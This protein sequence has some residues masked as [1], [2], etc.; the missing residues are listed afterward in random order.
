MGFPKSALPGVRSRDWHSLSSISPSGPGSV[1]IISVWSLLFGDCSLRR[2]RRP[3]TTANV[4]V[5]FDSVDSS[6]E[7]RPRCF[8]SSIS[9]HLPYHPIQS[10][11]Y[12]HL[13]VPTIFAI[14]NNNVVVVLVVPLTT[15]TVDTP[16]G[17]FRP[18]S[19]PPSSPREAPRNPI[20][21]SKLEGDQ[22]SPSHPI[23][24]ME[25]DP[26]TRELE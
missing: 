14:R 4:P 18:P 6:D 5:R 16:R 25:F 2:P 20:S 8:L 10:T 26:K 24:K 19:P 11:I 9:C 13:P 22:L 7:S 12:Q 15:V 17:I 3:V 1:S 23:V 21:N